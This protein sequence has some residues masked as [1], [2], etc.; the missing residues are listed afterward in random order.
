MTRHRP[1]PEAFGWEPEPAIIG[2]QPAH[3][4]RLELVVAARDERELIVDRFEGGEG[5]VVGVAR[6][7]DFGEHRVRGREPIPDRVMGTEA[8]TTS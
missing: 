1:E 3:R 6:C 8:A 5:G 4:I 7:R 2:G